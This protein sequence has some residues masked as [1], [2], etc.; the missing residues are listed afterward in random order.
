M[1][2]RFFKYKGYFGFGIKWERGSL[3]HYS[4]K[5]HK[6]WRSFLKAYDHYRWAKGIEN[7]KNSS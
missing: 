7:E 2:F 4:F 3:V 1:K 5:Y 6:W